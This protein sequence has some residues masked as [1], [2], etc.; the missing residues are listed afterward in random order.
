MVPLCY[1]LHRIICRPRS[2]HTPWHCGR[3]RRSSRSLELAP[4]SAAAPAARSARVSEHVRAQKGLRPRRGRCHLGK[5]QGWSDAGS[6]EGRFLVRLGIGL[7]WARAGV[8]P[9]L[10]LGLG[11]GYQG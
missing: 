1:K 3:R 11:L 2:R 4:L 10:G 5:A 6:G 7:E 9:G 8:G